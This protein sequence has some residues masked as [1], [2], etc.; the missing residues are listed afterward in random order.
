MEPRQRKNGVIMNN[1]VLIGSTQSANGTVYLHTDHL[2][3]VEA[4]TNVLGQF[5][6]RM[7]F[8]AWG[9]RQKAGG[10]NYVAERRIGYKALRAAGIS[11]TDARTQI[12]NADEYFRSIGVDFTTLTKIPGN[13]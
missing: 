2:G 12:L 10:G 7:S 5:V 4:T 11:K 9:E 13:R 3:S 8:G 6:N 1:R